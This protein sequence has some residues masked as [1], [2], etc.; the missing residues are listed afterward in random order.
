MHFMAIAFSAV[1]RRGISRH[2]ASKGYKG[3]NK[4]VFIAKSKETIEIYHMHIDN[5]RIGDASNLL[6][7]SR[8]S[9]EN[10]GGDTATHLRSHKT[11]RS[12]ENVKLCIRYLRDL[13]EIILKGQ[14]GKVSSSGCALGL[15]LGPAHFVPSEPVSCSPV[16]SQ[17]WNEDYRALNGFLF[18]CGPVSGIMSSSPFLT[19]D[20]SWLLRKTPHGDRENT[21][22]R[23]AHTIQCLLFSPTFYD[24]SL[25]LRCFRNLSPLCSIACD[26]AWAHSRLFNLVIIP[27]ARSIAQA[28]SCFVLF[29]CLSVLTIFEADDILIHN[30]TN[31]LTRC[32]H[33]S[34]TQ[35]HTGEPGIALPMH[36]FYCI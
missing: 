25:R 20:K 33:P 6:D 1:G 12:D 16:S 24:V 10:G 34:N 8:W 2:C 7:N 21:L 23:T 26:A 30:L 15:Q 29:L 27:K 22:Q 5:C 17:I 11:D 19:L 36:S 18:P 28:I 4:S 3:G 13:V 14:E 9:T 31:S 35:S 32:G